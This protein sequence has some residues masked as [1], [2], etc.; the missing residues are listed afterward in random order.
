MMSTQEHQTVDGID[1]LISTLDDDF[2]PSRL[3]ADTLVRL[4]R[5]AVVSESIFVGK[6]GEISD[7]RLKRLKVKLADWINNS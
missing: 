4:T 1:E 6:L 2:A 5:L 3:K 7:E